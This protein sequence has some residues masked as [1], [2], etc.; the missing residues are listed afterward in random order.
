MRQVAPVSRT[1]HTDDD[2]PVATRRHAVERSCHA[3]SARAP[4]GTASQIHRRARGAAREDPSRPARR[5][6]GSG[7]VAGSGAAD[8]AWGCCQNSHSVAPAAKRRRGHRATAGSSPHRS[9]PVAG[10]GA[11][12]CRMG[13]LPKFSLGRPGGKT[14]AAAT[15]PP[16]GRRPTGLARWQ[17]LARQTSHGSL[18][19]R[20]PG[21]LPKFSLCR[22]G[23]KTGCRGNRATTGSSP[24]RVWPGGRLWCGRLLH[25]SLPRRRPGLLPK[26]SLCRSGGKIACAVTAAGAVTWGPAGMAVICDPG[27]LK[28][29]YRPLTSNAPPAPCKPQGGTPPP[30]TEGAC[31][32]AG[33]GDRGPARL[34]HPPAREQCATGRLPAPASAFW[35]KQDIEPQMNANER[36]CRLIRQ[37]LLARRDAR[38]AAG[39]QARL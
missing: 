11:A 33:P 15:A 6:T 12:D 8:L 34:G 27:A 28:V 9:G 16:P 35:S 38:S 20:R 39:K 37:C 36:K 32:G 13:L 19:R 2:H 18:P 23:G 10:S 17:A 31:P 30:S 29:S 3:A 25:G 24:H 7:P 22:S 4:S 5:P 21:L 14:G 26:F 1:F